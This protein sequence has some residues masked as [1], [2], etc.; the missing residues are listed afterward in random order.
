MRCKEFKQYRHITSLRNVNISVENNRKLVP[1]SIKISL[2]LVPS[3]AQCL[4]AVLLKR[5]CIHNNKNKANFCEPNFVTQV[6][7]LCRSEGA[8]NM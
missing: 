5:I 7:M 8:G 3:N 6:S 1:P 2:P 4:L